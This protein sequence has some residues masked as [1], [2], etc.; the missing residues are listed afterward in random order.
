[1][2]VLFSVFP[3]LLRVIP[4]SIH[5]SV[6]LFCSVLIVFALVA[7]GFFML[8]AFGSP[9]ETLHGPV[10]LYLWSFISCEY[11]GLCWGWLCSQHPFQPRR[12]VKLS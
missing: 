4:A 9:Y 11:P 6:I 1:M 3:D 12:A 8:N 5:V 7:A 2:L 10:G